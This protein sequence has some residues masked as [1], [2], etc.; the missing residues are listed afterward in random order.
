MSGK[1]YRCGGCGELNPD[2]M[3]EIEGVHMRGTVTFNPTIQ[4]PDFKEEFCG[5]ME[6]L[7]LETFRNKM[8]KHG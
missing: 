2:G 4:G 5:E 3:D 6:L 8:R 1:V 7:V